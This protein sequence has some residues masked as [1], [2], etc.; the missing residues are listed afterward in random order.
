M[1]QN[2]LDVIIIGG[3]Y[4]GLSAAMALGRSLRRVLILDSG[5]PCNRQAPYSH[6][7][8][9][10][11]GEKPAEIATKAK[12][13]VLQ[14][15]TVLFQKGLAISGSKTKD[16]FSIM[17]ESGEEFNA[18]KLIFA[19]GMRD[20]MPDIMG[21]SDC[22][23]RSVVNC[24][25]CHGYEVKNEKTGILANGESAVHTAQMIRNWTKDLTV[26]TNG[27]SSLNKEQATKLAKHQIPVI[28]KEIVNLKNEN[29]QIKE[30]VF[31]DSSSSPVTIV[32]TS[33]DFEQHCKIPE[34]LGCELT[35]K[36][37]IQVDSS[38]K[39]TVDGIF[40]CGDN[41]S[42]MR[43]VANAVSAGNLAGG[44]VNSLLTEEEF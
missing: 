19:T 30:I 40:A 41:T 6:N 23:G 31:S 25:Y 7:F 24:P 42:S 26:F 17:T 35:E 29:G 18:K 32:Y 14:Y 4:A 44:V 22:W 13:Q 28:E 38:Q 10:Q 11:D 34:I 43:S 21:F 12:A 9:T 20:I 39:T 1:D 15:P 37:L 8:I 16:G 3:S 5:L 27:I 2:N 33:P 36:G